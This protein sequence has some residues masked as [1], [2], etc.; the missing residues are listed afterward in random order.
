MEY[1]FYHSSE[2]YHY[3]VKGMKW[4]VRKKSRPANIQY[5]YK[6]PDQVRRPR[7]PKQEY[8]HILS[9]VAI[10]ITEEQRNLRVFTRN[11]GKNVYT[12]L[13]NF[14]NTYDILG[15][16]AIRKDYSNLYKRSKK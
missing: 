3:G 14:D 8:A 15:K 6:T 12:I 5:S 2:L 1:V 7:L 11:I 10:H 9:E 16:K 4:G 13:N